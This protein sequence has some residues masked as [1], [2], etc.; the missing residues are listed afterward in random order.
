MKLR[1]LFKNIFPSI[2]LISGVI[3]LS[4]GTSY[5]L[6]TS[7]DNIDIN[8]SSAKLSIIPS[9]SVSSSVSADAY[10]ITNNVLTL[11]SLSQ[12]DELN[13]TLSLKNESSISSKYRILISTN[14]DSSSFTLKDSNNNSL[15][16]SSSSD[17]KGSYSNLLSVGSNPSDLTYSLVANSDLTNKTITFKI[18]V[19]QGNKDVSESSC[20]PT[21]I[22]GDNGSL[23]YEGLTTT[24]GKLII[25][26]TSGYSLSSLTIDDKTLT[27]D[28]LKK[29]LSI[30][31]SGNYIYNLTNVSDSTSVSASFIDTS[32]DY[33]IYKVTLD[34]SDSN[35]TLTSINNGYYS[36]LV[37][38]K[39]SATITNGYTI[40]KF[41]YKESGSDT[42]IELDDSSITIDNDNN[43]SLSLNSANLSI[44]ATSKVVS[45]TVPSDTSQGTITYT[46]VS[47]SVTI[48]YI[49]ITPST[50]YSLSTL[51]IDNKEISY[52]SL[53]SDTN[54]VLDQ[55]NG[56]Y[57]YYLNDL[58]SDIEV[59]A[60][61]T[62]TSI[63]SN[64]LTIYKLTLNNS[65]NITLSSKDNYLYFNNSLNKAYIKVSDDTNL[66][67]LIDDEGNK[68]TTTEEIEGTT[69]YV[70][71]LSSSLNVK[72]IEKSSTSSKDI[73]DALINN[74]NDALSNISKSNKTPSEVLDSL[75]NS[76]NSYNLYKEDLLLDEDNNDVY[77]IYDYD[78][79][80]IFKSND[81]SYTPSNKSNCYIVAFRSNYRIEYN[82]DFSEFNSNYGLILSSSWY[83]YFT[84]KGNNT[85]SSIKVN[86]NMDLKK[87]N[88]TKLGEI[89]FIS[90][91]S[92]T[93]E[94]WTNSNLCSGF[95]TSSIMYFEVNNY[96]S[97]DQYVY[98]ENTNMNNM[99]NVYVNYRSSGG[100]VYLN[101]G[102]ILNLI[103]YGACKIDGVTIDTLTNYDSNR[104]V[105][106]YFIG[107]DFS[108][109]YK[110]INKKSPTTS[111]LSVTYFEDLVGYALF[112]SKFDSN[113]Y[114]EG[115]NYSTS[116]TAKSITYL[117]DLEAIITNKN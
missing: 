17:Y 10:N 12:N 79:N 83:T 80:K 34:N 42:Y 49:T 107:N 13:I 87:A 108:N 98:L 29:N 116:T 57:K 38:L 73:N 8:I 92:R 43:Y 31:S 44:K 68:I 6:L 72:V 35:I 2:L 106:T 32:N 18:E 71:S 102:K 100:Y 88:L 30:D 75:Y 51:T 46:N 82:E 90:S 7:E 3:S 33:T 54:L 45:I 62:D 37:P 23:S 50:G 96:S 104:R 103:N 85:Y 114:K 91:C 59:S 84:N 77:P 70:A 11:N 19:V 117:T 65:T 64:D 115:T 89:D 1:N 15:S 60:T 53:K 93:Y 74:I 47:D 101:G 39:V 63:T 113:T 4:V 105:W 22:Q 16:L 112:L 86:R 40:D 56:N 110:F 5:S 111:Y 97:I 95:N 14:D 94:V 36:K 67:S 9:I 27:E 48:P 41:L 24:S 109:I 69:Y 25:T 76:N 55:V 20:I 28:E 78:S 26:P 66:D 99:Y 61:Y 52:E 21:I 81:T 58:N